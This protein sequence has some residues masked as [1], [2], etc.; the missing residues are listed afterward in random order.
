MCETPLKSMARHLCH[1]GLQRMRHRCYC[2]LQRVRHLRG[3]NTYIYMGHA[4]SYLRGVD[5]SQH[6]VVHAPHSRA[7]LAIDE[8]LHDASG[9]LVM[10]AYETPLL[11]WAISRDTWDI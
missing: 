7:E 1:N 4:H 3:Y 6:K 11:L 2:G 5:G 9:G 8:G 10:S